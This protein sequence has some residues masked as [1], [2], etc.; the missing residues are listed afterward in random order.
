MNAAEHLLEEGKALRGDAVEGGRGR[1]SGG[2]MIDTDLHGSPRVLN[3]K[4]PYAQFLDQLH[5][6]IFK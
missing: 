1:I 2:W 5:E 3:Q 6:R 4:T